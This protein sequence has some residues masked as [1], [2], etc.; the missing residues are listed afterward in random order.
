MQ[1]IVILYAMLKRMIHVSHGKGG[2]DR[3]V[4]LPQRTLEML[5]EYWKTHRNS[6]WLFPSEGKDHIALSKSTEPM[7]KSSVQDAFRASGLL[8]I[9]L[10]RQEA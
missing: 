1:I 10:A 3:Y 7:H 8:R 6:L 2:K 5:R 4:P 9:F